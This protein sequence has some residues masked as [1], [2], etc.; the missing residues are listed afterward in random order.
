[1]VTKTPG[2][3]EFYETEEYQTALDFPVKSFNIRYPSQGELFEDYKNDVFM[4]LRVKLGYYFQ[5]LT[6]VMYRGYIKNSRIFL[7]NKD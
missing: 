4:G 3:R 2:G 7:K 5:L 1:M 6:Q